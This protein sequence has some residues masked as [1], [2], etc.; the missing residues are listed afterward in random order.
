MTLVLGIEHRDVRVG[1][2]SD[3]AVAGMPPARATAM[4]AV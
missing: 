4:R 2:I 3:G 1:R